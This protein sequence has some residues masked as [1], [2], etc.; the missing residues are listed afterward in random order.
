MS[1]HSI[2]SEPV[3]SE[4]SAG[5]SPDACHSAID[6]LA[7]LDLHAGRARTKAEWMVAQAK[8]LEFATI[9]RGWDQKGKNPGSEFG[10]VELPC[11]R[12]L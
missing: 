7:A 1:T 3:N 11:L 2:Y 6:S 5:K 12:E 10:S 8:L 9:L 4:R